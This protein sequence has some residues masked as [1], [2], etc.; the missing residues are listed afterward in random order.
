MIEAST[1]GGTVSV[2]AGVLLIVFRV[3]IA[4]WNR[5]AQRRTF[6]RLADDTIRN[7]TPGNMVFV[8][9]SAIAIGG[10]LILRPLF[11]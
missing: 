4:R 11:A 7:S 2:I 6:G 8:G 1:L 5:R 10:F 9:V 3:R